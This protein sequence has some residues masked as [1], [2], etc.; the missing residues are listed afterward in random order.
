MATHAMAGSGAPVAPTTQ[1]PQGKQMSFH[2]L[3]ARTIDG[4][5]MSL[6]DYSGKVALVVNTASECGYTPQYAGL[7][8]LYQELSP[9]GLVVLGFPSNEFGG[10]EPG[11]E[12]QIKSF[13]S[14]K[15]NVSFPMF[16]KVET[17]PG[18]GQSPVYQFLTRNQPAPRWNFTKYLVGR[19]GQVIASY[20]SSVGPDSPELRQAIE[21]ALHAKKD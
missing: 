21:T 4:H 14:T 11:T 2:D 10:Q 13:C 6:K 8:K 19:D 12:A 7:Q 18:D 3:T 1:K 20:P 9:T 17:K 15:F 5:S 16:S